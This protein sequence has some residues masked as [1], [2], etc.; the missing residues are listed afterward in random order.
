[1]NHQTQPIFNK[2][3]LALLTVAAWLALA[4]TFSNCTC[5]PGEDDADCGP[6]VCYL[7]ADTF[8]KTMPDGRVVTM[9]G[10]AQETKFGG[11][12]GEVMSPG[13][14]IK[15]PSCTKK[16]IIK[17][18]NNLPEP[19][20]IVINGLSQA[21]TPVYNDDGRVRSFTQETPPGNTTPVKY[22]WENLKPGTFLYQS[23]THPGVQVQ[24][25]L[26]GALS[27]NWRYNKAYPDI[28]YNKSMVLVLS[29]IDADLHDAVATGNYGPGQAVTSP[30]N[31]RPQYFL[32]NGA[33]DTTGGMIPGLAQWAGKDVLLR[34]ANAGLKTRVPLLNGAY[35]KIIGEDGNPHLYPQEVYSLLIPAGKTIDVMVV[36]PD[37]EALLADR[38]FGS[39]TQ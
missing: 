38:R 33:P 25:G 5:N 39:P 18:D 31:Y 36:P 4:A 11:L 28:K 26:Y 7:R 29:E 21:M 15:I 32:I 24:M 12:R 8:E 14:V 19:T 17:L 35:F 2:R 20:S 13:P 16:L 3:R 1:M 22:V 34:F 37:T 30:I 10:Y 27:K 9:W 23:G 6:K